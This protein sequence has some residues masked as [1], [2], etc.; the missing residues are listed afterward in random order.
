MN[1]SILRFGSIGR[2]AC[3]VAPLIAA[4]LGCSS[5]IEN[6]G[7]PTATGA[8]GGTTV[9]TGGASGASGKAAGG[10]GN[11]VGQGGSSGSAGASGSGGSSGATVKPPM[12][13]VVS[14]QGQ[15]LYSRFLRLTVSQWENSVHD[16]LKLT[17]PTGLS[18]N[19][20]HAVGGTTDFD[21]N[22]RVVYVDDTAW[23]DFQGAAEAVANQ[24]TATDT[25]AQA[26][27]AGSDK[28][29]FIS[30]FGRR[31][32]R[33]DL[34]AAEV[35]SYGE[36]YDQGTMIATG[37]VSAFTK[38]ARYVIGAMLQSPNFLYRMEMGDV[39][40][41]LSGYELASKVSLW[42]RDTTPSDAM[43]DAAAAGTFD[44]AQGVAEQAQAMLA[45]PNVGTVMRRFNAELY[46]LALYDSITKVGVPEWSADM[47]PEMKETSYLFFDRIFSE[48]LGVTDIFMSTIG[49]V[50]PKT[51]SLYGLT[52]QGTQMRQVDTGRAG[53]Y[54][55]VPFLT[56]Q[57]RNNDPDSIHRGVRINTDA[58]CADPG[59]PSPDLPDI[60]PPKENQTNREIITGLT[61]TCGAECHGQVIN[62][63]GF[64]FED[65]DGMGR[66]R[67]TDNGSPVDT[68]GTYP[69]AEGSLDFANSGELMQLIAA[70]TQAHQCWAKKMASY[71][72][73]RDVVEVERPMIETLGAISLAGGSLKDVMIALVKE[74]NFR[75]HVGGSQ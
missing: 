22:E 33:R 53:Y 74:N 12:P 52:A 65:F 38:G 43:L 45:D 70:G 67:T 64:A 3:A 62:P 15:P 29:T 66:H 47:N 58:L 69:F 44:T 14:M 54:A 18:E 49:F 37:T 59:V 35:T 9:A 51:A 36:V 71:A 24:V 55:Q 60:P 40:A 68:A 8:T 11:A 32:F 63:I 28:S 42:I 30:K 72:L 5:S 2:I 7:G 39:G 17:A 4:T 75:T 26:I 20:Q 23:N 1:A 61:K 56:R 10:T 41:P 21:N 19:F 13:Q 31:A 27:G 73:Q 48:N 46:K 16:I 25:A 50:G 57:A 34:T 6:P